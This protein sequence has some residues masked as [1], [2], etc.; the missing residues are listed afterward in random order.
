MPTCPSAG[1]PARSGSA[2][3]VTRADL[4]AYVLSRVCTRVEGGPH[5]V[6]RAS[7]L[8]L[9]GFGGDGGAGAR[10]WTTSRVAPV[11]S[12]DPSL[13]AAL[14]CVCVKRPNGRGQGGGRGYGVHAECLTSRG[15]V[16]RLSFLEHVGVFL[17]CCALQSRALPVAL[18]RIH[19]RTLTQTR[20]S[21][22]R[23]HAHWAGKKKKAG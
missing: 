1:D 10:V 23:T 15:G 8:S 20:A 13:P 12:A 3:R 21:R 11:H 18:Q 7:H 6:Y 4:R 16:S 9:E 19:T 17:V 22:T 5:N 14:V 2:L